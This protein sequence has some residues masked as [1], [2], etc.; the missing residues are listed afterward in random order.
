[1]AIKVWQQTN[2]EFDDIKVDSKCNVKQVYPSPVMMT[3][4]DTDISV[5]GANFYLN[6]S[7]HDPSAAPCRNGSLVRAYTDYRDNS[8]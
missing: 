8:T 6:H 4:Y 7:M 3:D 5:S 1:M 2:T